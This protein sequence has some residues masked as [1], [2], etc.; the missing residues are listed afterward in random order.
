MLKALKLAFAGL[1]LI[2]VALQFVRPRA[3]NPPSEASRAVEAHVRVSP[4]VESILARSCMDC[5]SNRTEW[6][7]YSNVAPVSWFVADHVNHG[8][9]HLNFSD[10]ARLDR[11]EARQ[12]LDGI[13]VLTKHGSMPMRSYTFIH[14][15]AVLSPADVR[16][17]CDWS[18]EER[19]R[20]LAATTTE[21]T[22]QPDGD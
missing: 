16:A 17:L 14:R 2:F 9:K 10:W 15:D 12:M 7:W 19:R 11:E 4:E 6:P 20:L 21:R 5:H 3:F 1:A 18:Q 22:A 13:C 8:R